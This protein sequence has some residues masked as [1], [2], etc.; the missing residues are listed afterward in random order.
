MYKLIKHTIMKTQIKSIAFCLIIFFSSGLILT[1]NAQKNDFEDD[2]LLSKKE[3]TLKDFTSNVVHQNELITEFNNNAIIDQIGN[4]NTSIV[5]QIHAGGLDPN[6]VNVT[7]A[8]N[9]NDSEINQTGAGNTSSIN[10]DGNNNHYKVVVTGNDNNSNVI[11]NGNN[12]E[13][14]HSLVGNELNYELIQDG[15]NNG[16]KH[17]DFGSQSGPPKIIQEGN[18]MNL[19]IEQN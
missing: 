14:E 8:G 2:D 3:K 18:N 4:R 17:S 13:L 7:Q 1:V 6:I 16:L 5:N 11:Q 19:T 15:N 10:Q 9:N 12:N